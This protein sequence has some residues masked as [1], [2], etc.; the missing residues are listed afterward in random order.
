MLDVMGGS[1][2][3]LHFPLALLSGVFYLWF[4][5]SCFSFREKKLFI[6]FIFIPTENSK[7]LFWG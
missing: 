7:Y 6:E 2:L 1:M 5:D 3:L 4:Y